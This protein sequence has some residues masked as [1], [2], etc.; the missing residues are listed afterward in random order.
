MSWSAIRG[1]GKISFIKRWKETEDYDT[2]FRDVTENCLLLF[3][4][5]RMV[6]AG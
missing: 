1:K 5:T 3:G 6:N 4:L 2:E